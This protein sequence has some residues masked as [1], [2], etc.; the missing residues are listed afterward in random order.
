MPLDQAERISHF[1]RLS[2][3]DA[4]EAG[5]VNE[6]LARCIHCC[7]RV[8]QGDIGTLNCRSECVF[9]RNTSNLRLCVGRECADRRLLLGGEKTPLTSHLVVE[10]NGFASQFPSL[11]VDNTKL[12]HCILELICRLDPTEEG[13]EHCSSGLG[14]LGHPI[15]D[16]LEA[17]CHLLKGRVH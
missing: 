4:K 17:L 1:P 10:V 5:L 12:D 7:L 2:G 8:C 16:T 3:I 9:A 15:K 13:G 14:T 6:M 11:G